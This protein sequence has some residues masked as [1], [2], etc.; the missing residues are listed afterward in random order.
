MKKLI[1]MM[2]IISIS[3][4]MISVIMLFIPQAFADPTTV[5]QETNS[6]AEAS[7]DSAGNITDSFNSQ[8]GKNNRGGHLIAPDINYPS[9]INYFGP[10]EKTEGYQPV[11]SLVMYGD[12]FTTEALRNILK[13]GPG[14]AKAYFMANNLEAQ[15][16]G[17]FSEK[18]IKHE[19]GTTEKVTYQWIKIIIVRDVLPD[20]RGLG[21]VMSKSTSIST[22]M[23]QV[24]AAAALKAAEEGG[25][26]AIQFIAQG[27]TPD[28]YQKGWGIGFNM[29]AGKIVGDENDTAI[30]GGGGTGISRNQAGSRSLPWLQG[31]GLWISD[32]TAPELTGPVVVKKS[33]VQIKE[34]KAEQKQMISYLHNDNLHGH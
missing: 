15:A 8:A 7:I 34:A 24:M 18:I 27:A 29:S 21:Y 30:L 17:L 26:N 2:T 12:F 14:D 13:L 19:D 31:H 20:A 25:C 32:L 9:P 10:A 1:G 6:N 33:T 11:E 22:A 28:V 4:I 5:S 16:P 3:V 23:P